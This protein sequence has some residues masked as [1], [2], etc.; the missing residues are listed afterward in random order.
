[1]AQPEQQRIIV[2]KHRLIVDENTDDEMSSVA[3]MHPQRME[4]LGIMNDD[5]ILIH[6]KRRHTSVCIVEEDSDIPENGI[7]LHRMVRYNA[8][9]KLGDVVGVESASE[10]PYLTRIAVAPLDDTIEG[11]E[12]ELFETFLQPYF[13]DVFRPIRVGDH[14][15]CNGAMRSVEFKVIKLDEDIECG[16]VM[17]D[18]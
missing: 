13:A 17:Q 11:L 15:V 10:M 2:K 1:M 12:G 7:K 5:M 14:F 8:K 6:G 4:D 18:T 9:V 3:F 16:I